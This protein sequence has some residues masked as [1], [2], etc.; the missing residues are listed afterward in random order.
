MRIISNLV[1]R[2]SRNWKRSVLSVLTWLMAFVFIGVFFGL[3]NQDYYNALIFCLCFV[4]LAYVCTRILNNFIIPRYLLTKRYFRFGL[5]LFYL[6]CLSLSIETLIIAGLFV[7]VWN[8][9]LTGID[10]ATMDVRFFLVGLYFVILVG[11]VYRQLQRSLQEQRLREQQDKIKVETELRLKEAELNLLKAQVNPHFLFNS[12]NSIYG[13][14][15]E[16]S[17]ETPR[18]IMLLSE[19]LDY[20]LYGCN[21]KFV[22]I[23]KEIELVENYANIQKGRFGEAIFLDIDLEVGKQ[24]NEMIAPL[25]L[26]PLVENAFKHTDRKDDV[27]STIAIHLDLDDDFCFRIKNPIRITNAPKG[28]GGIG[29]ENLRKRLELIYPARHELNIKQDDGCFDVELRLTII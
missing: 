19:I 21:T 9:S 11:V 24:M 7:L 10:P 14:S 26:L 4:P 29:L 5:Y 6:L 12:L 17:E 22:P 8:Y 18:M 23:Y 3:Y 13:L 25:L 15:L 1:R 20:T 27:A 2:F 28:N 16:K